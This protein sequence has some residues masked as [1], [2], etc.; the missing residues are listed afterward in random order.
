MKHLNMTLFSL[1][2]IGLSLSSLSA[3]GLA[4]LVIPFLLWRVQH[5]EQML[6]AQFGEE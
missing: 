3:L 4:I 5:E 6:A 1:L 2:G